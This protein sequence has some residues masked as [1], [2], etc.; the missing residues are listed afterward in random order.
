MSNL[1]RK[2]HFLG[3]KIRTIRKS[4]KLT[5]EDLSER[6]S[7]D[8]PKS[9]P[10][11]SYLSMIENG[12]RLP[13][14][15]VLK[16]IAKIFQKKTEWFLDENLDISV[17]INEMDEL[18]HFT[19]PLEPG[20]LYSKE[21]LQ[22]AIPELLEQTGISG[23]QFA[24]LL[25]RS[26]QERNKNRFPDLEK[27]AEEIG[28][29]KFPLDHN[30]LKHLYK[31]HGLKIKWFSHKTTETRPQVRN[32]TLLRS[33]FESPSEVY[34]NKALKQD[35]DR[36]KYDLS[37]HL[38]HKILHQGDGLR[39][40]ISSGDNE[41]GLNGQNLA[42]TG[43][44][45]SQDV[46][47]AWHDFESSFFA[48]ALLC[49]K[50]PFYRYLIRNKHQVLPA[51][52]LKLSP[53]LLMRRV[54][55]VSSYTYWHYFEAYQPG[56]LTAV[57]RGNGIP[58]PWGNMTMV[59]DPCPNWAVFRLLNETYV[60]NPQSQISILKNGDQNYLYCCHTIRVRDLA[61]NLK[62]LSLGIDL[63]PAIKNQGIDGNELLQSLEEAC[64]KNGGEA[65]L[66]SSIREVVEKLSHILRIQWLSESV[67]VPAR[68]ICPRSLSCQRNK[69][70][71]PTH[72][73]QNNN[74]FESIREDILNTQN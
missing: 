68:I 2:S 15:D 34:V 3:I 59:S 18:K 41:F 73:G 35:S 25:I 33:F 66:S 26:Y 22:G 32:K 8:N 55:A 9:A 56:Y 67:N 71:I 42:A 19:L 54:T 4:N 1:F 6:C 11:V 31:K 53:A 70:C 63:I 21:Q 51:Q 57:Y 13:S 48:G 10:S 23:K 74:G 58:L 62:L 52:Q 36:L 69:K 7:E 64:Q 49:P 43:N 20:F 12:K 16:Q 29:K 24:Q 65:E 37:V 45:H 38:G 40:A 27:A 5:L 28:N 61:G 14:D 39:S 50:K 47:S 72:S 60:K 44:I 17:P 46:L 30:D